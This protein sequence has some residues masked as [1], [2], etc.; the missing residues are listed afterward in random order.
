MSTQ[1]MTMIVTD[2]KLKE[3]PGLR[4][5]EGEYLV[6]NDKCYVIISKTYSLDE[7]HTQYVL[8]EWSEGNTGVSILSA[9]TTCSSFV[10]I[11]L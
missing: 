6:Y 4:L 11:M 7:Q 2:N 10:P 1:T 3:C 9:V 8:E 5:S